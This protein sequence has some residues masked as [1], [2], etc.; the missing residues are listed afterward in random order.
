MQKVGACP[1]KHR[2]EV[3]AN[4]LHTLSGEIAH[5]SLIHLDL[6][7]AVWSAILYG[8]HHGQTFHHRPSHTVRLDIFSEV[9]YL[10]ACPYFAERYVVQCRYDA[11]DTDLF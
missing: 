11:F 1:V 3:I 8:L 9:A 4:T 2:H 6:F 5:R 7:V 10:L